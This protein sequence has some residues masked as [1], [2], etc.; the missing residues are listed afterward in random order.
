MTENIN[1]FLKKNKVKEGD[2]VE[3]AG[4]KGNLMKGT[5]IPSKENVLALKL[6]NGYNVGISQEKIKS[7]KKIGSGKKVGKAKTVEIKKA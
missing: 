7:V 2:I 1:E 6:E 5:I 4:K 3:I